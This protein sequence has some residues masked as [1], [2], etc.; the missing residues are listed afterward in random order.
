MDRKDKDAI[1]RE[2]VNKYYEYGFRVSFRIIGDEEDCRDILQDAF[3]KVWLK[4]ETYDNKVKFSTWLFTIITNLCFDRLRKKKT[5]ANYAAKSENNSV[6]EQ[7]SPEKLINNKEIRTT[8]KEL[9]DK[10]SPKQKI[11][12]VLRDLEEL[13]MDEVCAITHLPAEQLKANLYHARKAI[14]ENL[15]YLKLLEDNI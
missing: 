13:E 6:D 8:L 9:S 5:I 12:F 7:Y 2:W 11:V 4:L 14:R 10:L 15:V 3:L 1:F